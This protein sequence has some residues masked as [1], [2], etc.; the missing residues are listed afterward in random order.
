VAVARACRYVVGSYIDASAGFLRDVAGQQQKW[1]RLIRNSSADT[2]Q[3]EAQIKVLSGQNA[4]LKADQLQHREQQDLRR[5]E[6][7]RSD[8]EVTV[9]AADSS[10]IP[11]EPATEGLGPL[12]RPQAGIVAAEGDGA[13]CES[14]S[15]GTFTPDL[16]A[17]TVAPMQR[18]L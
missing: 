10:V 12:Q 6:R 7:L 4:G 3:L 15:G 16:S 8:S 14:K 17:P 5:F 9:A 18:P 1:G 13:L 11:P 2:R